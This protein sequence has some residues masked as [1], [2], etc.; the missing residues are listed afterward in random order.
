MILNKYFVFIPTKLEQEIQNNTKVISVK[1]SQR[2]AL[3]RQAQQA[4]G[5]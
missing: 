4:G 1:E 2:Q 5:L 3:V